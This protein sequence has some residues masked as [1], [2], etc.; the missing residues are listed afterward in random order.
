MIILALWPSPA[1]PQRIVLAIKC[2]FLKLAQGKQSSY[3]DALAAD[4]I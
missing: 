1:V 2:A 4:A 3:I